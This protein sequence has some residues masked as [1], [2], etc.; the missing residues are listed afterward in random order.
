MYEIYVNYESTQ[1]WHKF[2]LNY[3][4]QYIR[5]YDT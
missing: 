4:L 2:L 3:M 5:H 1:I